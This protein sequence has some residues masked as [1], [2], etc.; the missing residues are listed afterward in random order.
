MVP[1]G[2]LAYRVGWV[3]DFAERVRESRPANTPGPVSQAIVVAVGGA[4]VFVPLMRVAHPEV[5]DCTMA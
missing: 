4:G 3:R 5:P 2:L 1:S